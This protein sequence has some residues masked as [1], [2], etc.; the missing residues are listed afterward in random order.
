MYGL[1]ALMELCTKERSIVMRCPECGKEMQFSTAPLTE[2]FQGEK[3]TVSGLEYYVCPKCGEVVMSAR[4]ATKQAKDMSRQ[5][6]TLQGLLS[7]EEIKS[8]RKGLNLNQKQFQE[9][10]G[11]KDPTV[12]RWERGS[13]VQSKTADQLMRILR[14]FPKVARALMDRAEIK[15]SAVNCYGLESLGKSSSSV[16]V[17][18]FPASITLNSS[19]MTYK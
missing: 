18:G 6:A 10:V 1:F 15:Y 17:K 11:V 13:C 16:H 8:I 2:T 9:L 3:F 12:C 4:M 14:A 7:P 19:E 5:L